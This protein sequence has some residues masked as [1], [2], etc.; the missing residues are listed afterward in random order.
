[1]ILY[2]HLYTVTNDNWSNVTHLFS[3]YRRNTMEGRRKFNVEGMIDAYP[4]FLFLYFSL[5]FIYL[6]IHL[7][8]YLQLYSIHS[9]IHPIGLVIIQLYFSFVSSHPSYVAISGFLF[10]L[11]IWLHDFPPR[12]CVA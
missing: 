1:M 5:S 4:Y 6:S 12:H 8:A 10:R 3:E 2:L 9:F 7:F 11:F